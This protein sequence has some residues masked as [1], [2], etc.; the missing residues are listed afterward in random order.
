MVCGATKGIGRAIAL[1][2]AESGAKVIIAGRDNDNLQKVLESF[3]NGHH[4]FM[5]L[6]QEDHE[7]IER[8]C[9][10]VSSKSISILVNNTGGPNPGN[11]MDEKWDNFETALTKQLRC[12]HLLS[13]SVL[14][15]MRRE[16]FGRILNIIS[17]SVRVP[18]LGLGVSNT[19]RGAVASWSKTLSIETAKYGITVNNL[20][21]GFIS[22]E[23][24]DQ[25]AE[26][27]ARVKG[28]SKDHQ[29]NEMIASIPVGRFGLPEELANLTVFL[30][31]DK[32]SYIT[33]QSILIDGG[34]TGII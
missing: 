19:V 29:R 3:P 12:S 27:Q 18:I 7:S 15:N 26:T 4:E 20:L 10:I 28:I 30:S 1:G 16:N 6:D 14:P 25:I 22:T 9:N 24:L 21:P 13:Q 5:L 2:M 23:R 17:S 34:K 8:I 31:S 33:G 32:A 11:I